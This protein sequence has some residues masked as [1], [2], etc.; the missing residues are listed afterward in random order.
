[1]Q[2]SLV[3]RHLHF[4]YALGGK[5]PSCLSTMNLPNTQIQRHKT[6][7]SDRWTLRQARGG[8]E[9]LI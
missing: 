8:A 5:K 2:I 6:T 4:C 9:R 3:L 7:P 1:V